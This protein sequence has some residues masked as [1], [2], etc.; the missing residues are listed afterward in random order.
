MITRLA[1]VTIYV[2][3]QDEALAF[4]TEKLGLEKRSDVTFG[5]GARWLTVAPGGQTDFEILLQSP[6]P[7]MHGEEFAQ[8]ISERVGQGTTWVFFTDDCR[9]DYAMLTG[10][11]VSFSSEPQEQP[12]GV[13]A[14]FQDLYGNSFSL[15][16]PAAVPEAPTY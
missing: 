13:E 9:A 15:L 2:H 4:Y 1:R 11:G 3:D 12:Y 16:Q 7:A 8:K 6:V 14:V 10:R 5:P